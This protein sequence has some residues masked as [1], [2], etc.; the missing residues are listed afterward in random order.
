MI[1]RMHFLTRPSTVERLRG[2]QCTLADREYDLVRL[3]LEAPDPERAQRTQDGET[4]T[5]PV[6]AEHLKFYGLVFEAVR[7]GFMATGYL[8]DLGH[9]MI[10][11]LSDLLRNPINF[12]SI[13]PRFHGQRRANKH[14]GV[15]R[16]GDVYV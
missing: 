10:A 14:E 8:I 16:P 2:V 5:V 9:R 7:G 1:V 6:D 15:S 4:V 12:V 13:R 11:D 3:S